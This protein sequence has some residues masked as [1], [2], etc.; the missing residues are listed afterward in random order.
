MEGLS[1]L[2]A[3]GIVDAYFEYKTRGMEILHA[4]TS[5]DRP[6]GYLISA[7]SAEELASKLRYVDSSI[8]VVADNGED[9]MIHG[10]LS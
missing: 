2:K 3:R 1:E 8:K 10:L 6:A 7:K 9:I 4:E 5:G